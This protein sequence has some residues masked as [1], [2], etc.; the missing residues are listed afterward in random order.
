M[1][2]KHIILL[3][4]ISLF[5]FINCHPDPAS[6]EDILNNDNL[7]SFVKRNFNDFVFVSFDAATADTIIQLSNDWTTFKQAA[8]DMDNFCSPEGFKIWYFDRFL[9][10]D[11]NWKNKWKFIYENLIGNKDPDSG[12]YLTGLILIISK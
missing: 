3:S 1:Y 6:Y 11:R 10:K 9:Y 7:V 8:L 5:C 12:E 4:L 2:T